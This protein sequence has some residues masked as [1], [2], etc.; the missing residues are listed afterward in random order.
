MGDVFTRCNW[1]LCDAYVP[2][3]LPTPQTCLTNHPKNRAPEMATKH[4]FLITDS[5]DPHANMLMPHATLRDLTHAG[6][7]VQPFFIGSVRGSSEEQGFDVDKFYSI[8]LLLPPLIFVFLHLPYPS[9]DQSDLLPSTTASDKDR[10]NKPL[11]PESISIS[12]IDDLLSDSLR[13]IS[14]RFLKGTVHI[15]MELGVRWV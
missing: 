11:I 12:R 4:I 13:C 6:V 14:T 7:A 9:H 8:C 2:P 3:F 10:D 1:V 5:D 15:G